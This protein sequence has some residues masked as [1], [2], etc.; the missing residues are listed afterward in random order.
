MPFVPD[1]FFGLNHYRF[2]PAHIDWAPH[3][4]PGVELLLIP[5]LEHTKEQ[6]GENRTLRNDS[7]SAVLEEGQQLIDRYA[8]GERLAQPTRQ[9]RR[10]GLPDDEREWRAERMRN[11][12]RKKRAE[13][14]D[15]TADAVV[16]DQN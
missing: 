1:T 2:H 8:A 10:S 13:A 12:R 11:Y 14:A 5:I 3:C 4:R 9:S 7:V 15:T 16:G 6:F